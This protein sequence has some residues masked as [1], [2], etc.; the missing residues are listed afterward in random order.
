MKM[1]PVRAWTL[2]L[3]KRIPRCLVVMAIPVLLATEVLISQPL[4]EIAISR[5]DQVV[6]DMAC[7]D[8]VCIATLAEGLF[9]T[10]Y[11][12]RSTDF[13]KTW[14]RVYEE[15]PGENR[16]IPLRG[17]SIEFLSRNEILIAA[18]S[19]WV[20]RSS[21]AGLT[22]S[23]HEVGSTR[24]G[25]AGRLAMA[26][27]LHGVVTARRYLFWYSPDP[28][29]LFRT[30]DGGITW[31]TVPVQPREHPRLEHKEMVEIVSPAV[32]Q[33][34]V[35]YTMPFPGD[36]VFDSLLIFAY[37]ENGGRSWSY[38]ELK[39]E[40]VPYIWRPSLTFFDS[41]NAIM[42]GITSTGRSFG[43]VAVTSDGGR[44]WGVRKKGLDSTY[45]SNGISQSHFES[46]L[47]GVAAY[48]GGVARTT[49]GGLTWER[50]SIPPLPGIGR[51]TIIAVHMWDDSTGVAMTDA[52]A[53]YYLE[54]GVTEV[55]DEEK[56]ESLLSS[57]VW[58]AHDG[59]GTCS[60][61]VPS[62]GEV[63]VRLYDVVGRLVL[64]TDEVVPAG[65]RGI[66]VPIGSLA[67]GHYFL[68]VS[69]PDGMVRNGRVLIR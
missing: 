49:D 12:L 33:Y 13:G 37:S 62:A 6:F 20:L 18:D 42:T 53:F 10:T 31:D 45:R 56:A 60:V 11:I 30:D 46:P 47:K 16:S 67:V 61:S 5:N 29:R 17:E 50:D 64:E 25:D 38:H 65:V 21:D 27:S 36:S 35:L 1:T 40:G 28:D 9:F 19:S 44:S 48:A 66:P 69:M 68:E 4:W 52:G 63:R 23:E 3:V 55:R 57:R 39:V 15:Q 58:N 14:M 7:S 24:W 8:Q 51:Q 43:I 26:D 2:R 54:G 32:N 59:V 34:L 22:W 41:Q